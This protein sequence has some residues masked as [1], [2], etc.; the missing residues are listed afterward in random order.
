MGI[1]AF[2]SATGSTLACP[3]CDS[4]TGKAVRAKIFGEDFVRNL[5]ATMAPVPVLVVFVVGVSKWL[6][7]EK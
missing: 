6:G 5:L 3:V 2:V 7:K 4:A 1:V